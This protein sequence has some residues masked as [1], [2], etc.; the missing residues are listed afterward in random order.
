MDLSSHLT[1]APFGFSD[2]TIALLMNACWTVLIGV[3]IFA[4]ITNIKVQDSRADQTYST[5]KAFLMRESSWLHTGILSLVGMFGMWIV[6]T[7]V[8]DLR[9]L[10]SP[11][12]IGLIL[13]S[14]FFAAAVGILALVMTA[15]SMQPKRINS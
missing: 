2:V 8:S 14:G 11:W 10:V 1:L 12:S 6:L 15:W 7:C 4:L 3:V 13:T 9:D 5:F